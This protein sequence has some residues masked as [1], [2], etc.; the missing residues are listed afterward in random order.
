[1]ADDLMLFDNSVN[2]RGVRR[3][4]LQGQRTAQ[5]KILGAQINRDGVGMYRSLEHPATCWGTSSPAPNRNAF[6]ISID[7]QEGATRD[8]SGGA[9]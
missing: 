9:R 6:L 2:R 4:P 7:I 8:L 1:M 3:L 5:C